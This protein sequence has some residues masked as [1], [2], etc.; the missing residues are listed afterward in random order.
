MLRDLAISATD[1]KW[2]DRAVLEAATTSRKSRSLIARFAVTGAWVAI[3]VLFSVLIPGTFLRFDNFNTIVGSQVIILML[4]VAVTFPLR[5][6]DFDLSIGAVAVLSASIVAVLTTESHWPVLLAVAAALLLCMVVGAVNSIIIVWFGADAFVTTLG[7]MTIVGGVAYGITNTSIV[8]GIP[9]S[10]MTATNLQ[11]GGIP[12]SAFFGWALVL[13]VWYV[14]EYTPYGRYLL[15]LGG[16]REVARMNGVPVRRVRA[17]AL[18]ISS[19]IA[20]VAGILLVGTLGSIDPSIAP[21]YLIPPYA[22]AFVGATT[23]QVGR[24][25]ILGTV[26]GVYMLATIG[27]GLQLVGASDWLGT[28][29]SGIALVGAI[30][31]GR[32]MGSKSAS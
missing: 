14:F 28:V 8:S 27:L 19:L 1:H 6:G 3:I 32:A 12:I 26:V 10:L 9:S 11:V 13:I 15:F 17:G 22:A 20:G 18:I 5:A 24:F 25:N 31:F 23:I 16:N 29:F 30:T 7:T 4:A 2:E 21:Q